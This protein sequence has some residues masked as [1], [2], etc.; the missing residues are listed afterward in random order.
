[1]KKTIALAIVA[2]LAIPALLSAAKK[3]GADPVVMKIGGNDVK[4]S[5][6]EYLYKKNNAQLETDMTLDS[7]IDMFV[8]YKLKV[9]AAKD[10]GI[11][12]TEAYLRD[13]KMYASE[14]SEPYM[15]D[16]EMLDSLVAAAYSHRTEVVAIHHLLLPHKDQDENGQLAFADSLRR[17][18]AAGADFEEIIR[19]HSADPAAPK[20]SGRMLVTGGFLP[21]EFEDMA[22]N[23]PVGQL[24]PVFATQFG[25]HLIRVDER[26]P[27]PGEVKTR[28]IL[29]LTR[30]LPEDRHSA[31]LAEIDSLRALIASGADFSSIA[32]EETEDPSGRAN[33]GDLPWFGPGRMVPEF[34]AAA[35]S[36][37]DGEL[38]QP[39]KTDFGYHLILREGIRPVAPVDSVRNEIEAFIAR[40]YRSGLLARRAIARYAK[41]TGSGINRNAIKKV[42]SLLK[43]HG[44]LNEASRQKIA[45]MK[46]AAFTVDGQKYSTSAVVEK[47]GDKDIKDSNDAIKAYGSALENIFT[48]KTGARMRATLADREPAYRNLM[49]EYSDGMLLYEISNR[50][51]WDRA[52]SDQEGLEAYFRSHRDA[53]SWDRPHY[54]GYV[55][56]A[57]SDSIASE[58]VEYLGKLQAEDSAYVTE[59]RKK[60][61]TKAKIERVI[62]AKGASP[63]IDHIAFGAPAPEAGKRWKAYRAFR[64]E[65][66]EQPSSAMDVKGLVGM[67][68][69][70]ELEEQWLKQLHE[71]YSVEVDR[72]LIK[73]SI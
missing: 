1:M 39:V 47:L 2:F 8:N 64:G 36:L 10:A 20:Q 27:H 25:L 70:Q 48:E 30:N 54:K 68:Y 42:N 58:A 4:M 69:Q 23:T 18:V 24:S 43:K 50:L 55:V 56:S 17:L 22:Y 72:D 71:K 16:R 6:F 33:G 28:H 65:V 46:D 3:T 49:N 63:V 9:C 59:L 13:M 15:T 51:V 73:S 66:A 31:V 21:Y 52:N 19:K 38:S 5:E 45:S 35:Y 7:Y 12:T 61:G 41:S 32:K 26:R 29:K 40:D 11:D 34:E 37:S 14:L 60:F 53:Y 67:D 62:T 57:E 44:G